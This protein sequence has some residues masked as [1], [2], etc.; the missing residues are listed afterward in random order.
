VLLFK[1]GQ[2]EMHMASGEK[3]IYFADGSEKIIHKELI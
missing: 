1:N 3:I 2:L